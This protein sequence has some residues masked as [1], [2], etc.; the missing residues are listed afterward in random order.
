[1]AT[2]TPVGRRR[3]ISVNS[4]VERDWSARTHWIGNFA[5]VCIFSLVDLTLTVLC[6]AFTGFEELAQILAAA[7]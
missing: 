6:L 2:F 4:A 3:R 5:A 7:G 1:M